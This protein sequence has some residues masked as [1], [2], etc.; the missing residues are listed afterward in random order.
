M[1]LNRSI[2]PAIELLETRI[3]PAGIITITPDGKTATW[4]DIDGDKATLKITKGILTDALFTKDQTFTNGLLVTKLN[5]TDVQFKGTG[6]SLASKRDPRTGGDAQVNIGYIDATGQPLGVVKLSG[7]LG[8]IDAGD[9]L[10]GPKTPYAIKSLAAF[11]IGA[12][13]GAT[14]P[15]GVTENSEVTGKVGI[16]SIR[17]SIVG[18]LFNVTGGDAGSIDALNIGGHL[19]GTDDADSGRV[20]TSGK[21]GKISIKGNIY[22]GSGQHSGSIDAGGAIGTVSVLGSIFGGRSENPSTDGTG[23]IRTDSTIGVVSIGGNLHGGSQQDSGLIA[24]AGNA[25]AIKILG[26]IIGGSAGSSSGGIFIGGNAAGISIK[27]DVLG[28]AAL[29]SGVIQIGGKAGLVSLLGS[30]TGG[31][32]EGSGSITIGTDVSEIVTGLSIGRDVKGGTGEDSGSIVVKGRVSKFAVKGTVH[33]GEGDASGLIDLGNGAVTAAIGGDLEGGSGVNSGRVQSGG[34]ITTFTIGGNLLGGDADGAGSI[35]SSARIGKLGIS[36]S[37]LGPDLAVGATDD[38]VNSALI[39]AGAIKTLTISGAL[40]SGV[41]ASAAA[42]LINTAAIRVANEIG[43]LTIARGVEGNAETRVFITARGQEVLPPNP[44][45][46]VAM[47]NINI[48]GVRF[49][50]ILAGY[51]TTTDATDAESNPNASIVNVGIRGDWVASNLVAGAKWSDNFGD[52]IHV[53]A[54][55]VDDPKISARIGNISIGGHVFGTSDSTTDHYGFVAESIRQ[56]TIGTTVKTVATVGGSDTPGG[57]APVPTSP[58]AVFLAFGRGNDNDLVST[59][60][61]LASTFDVRVFEFI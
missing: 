7:D 12:A 20:S 47:G 32:G 49:A 5:L 26:G 8:R 25:G 11:S 39:Q 45:T 37:V 40:R 9:P 22:G 38:V 59:R 42:D 33:G 60:Y 55:G 15:V 2:S 61:N 23:V 18:A 10:I 29:E 19:I 41:D 3:A 36:G 14:L 30:L 28:G 43:A 31:E 44:T 58:F 57:A 16:V 17:G 27:G 56:M 54:T 1:K 34:A 53:K 48:G 24:A 13:E 35:V 50:N 4:D 6:V 21:I 52:S 46:D 51:D